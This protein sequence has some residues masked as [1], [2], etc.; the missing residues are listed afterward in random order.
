MIKN[1]MKLFV[2]GTLQDPDIVELVLEHQNFTLSPYTLNGYKAVMAK[3]EDFPVLIESDSSLEGYLLLNLAAK[4]IERIKYYEGE[5]FELK[6][7]KPGL[8][9]FLPTTT[10]LM[11]DRPWCIS[12]LNKQEYLKRVKNYLKGNK[13]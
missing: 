1:I 8:Y 2:Y 3:D 9:T 11:T 4:D 5:E 6:E 12:G 13:W 7:I 10:E